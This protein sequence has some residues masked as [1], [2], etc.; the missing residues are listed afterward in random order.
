MK[1]PLESQREKDKWLAEIIIQAMRESLII[2]AIKERFI[3]HEF[4]SK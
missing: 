2:Q 3:K 1:K 4:K